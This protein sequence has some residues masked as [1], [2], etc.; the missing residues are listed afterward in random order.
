MCACIGVGKSLSALPVCICHQGQPPIVPGHLAEDGEH[1][2][3]Y[4]REEGVAGR[5]LDQP[6]EQGERGQNLVW[7]GGGPGLGAWPEARLGL[8]DGDTTCS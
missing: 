6:E 2:Q 5:W 4:L 1:E 7:E 3:Q 8:C